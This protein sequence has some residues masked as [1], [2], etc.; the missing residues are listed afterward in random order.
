MPGSPGLQLPCGRRHRGGVETSAHPN[1]NAV[2]AQPIAH[3]SSQQMSELV[4]VFA[5]L[6]VPDRFFCRQVPIALDAGR[7]RRPCHAV[8]RGQSLHI[9][10][11]AG[12]RILVEI[13][14]QEIGDR[15][16]VELV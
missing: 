11:G 7:S 3:R 2:C 5:R 12:G 14:E 9:G 16:I 8:C 6:L 15:E 4:D 1:P 13:E 10:E